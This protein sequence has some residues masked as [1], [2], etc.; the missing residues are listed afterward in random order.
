MST[1]TVWRGNSGT[2]QVFLVLQGEHP[3][4]FIDVTGLDEG[5]LAILRGVLCCACSRFLGK[6]RTLTW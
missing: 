6:T 5:S 2:V 4:A 3:V 1:D